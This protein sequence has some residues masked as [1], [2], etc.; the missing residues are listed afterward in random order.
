MYIEL[1]TITSAMT[2]GSV[3]LRTDLTSI[4]EANLIRFN[5]DSRAVCCSKLKIPVTEFD[6]QRIQDEGY[7]IDQIISSLSPVF[8]PAKTFGIKKEKVYT[9]K[10]KPFDGTCTF[11]ENNLCSIHEF[12]PFACQIYPFSLEIVDSEEIKILLHAEEICKSIESSNYADSDNVTLLTSI[13]KNIKTE[14]TARNIP[15]Y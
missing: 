1:P 11:L 6:I 8:L 14:L 10:R 9:L 5:C 7:E 13:L 4:E 2:I 15:I 12:K 3:N